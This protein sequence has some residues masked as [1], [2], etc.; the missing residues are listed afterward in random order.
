MQ[1]DSDILRGNQFPLEKMTIPVVT[2]RG[3]YLKPDTYRM[4]L[5]GVRH[6]FFSGIKVANK[7]KTAE[8]CPWNPKGACVL[9]QGILGGDPKVNKNRNQKHHASVQCRDLLLGK[10]GQLLR[11]Y[12][13]KLWHKSICW[14]LLCLFSECVTPEM[15]D[16]FPHHWS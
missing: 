4:S 2:S 3:I 5:Y 7:L 10:C 13:I 14:R 6:P 8:M 12:H 15:E 11:K 16:N 1:T 9:V